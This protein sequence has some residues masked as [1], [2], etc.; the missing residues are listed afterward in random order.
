MIRTGFV[1]RH[2]DV[3]NEANKL[4]VDG[5][6]KHTLSTFLKA[7]LQHILRPCS[8]SLCRKI[9]RKRDQGLFF[10]A[11]GETIRH[12]HRFPCSCVPN[13]D[14]PA[15][16]LDQRMRAWG[17]SGEIAEGCTKMMTSWCGRQR[18]RHHASRF[19]AMTKEYRVV[20]LVGT[21]MSEKFMWDS[22]MKG[23]VVSSQGWKSLDSTSKT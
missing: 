22:Y 5:C 4:F 7:N 11:R 10:D 19:C 13:E 6:T 1:S 8:W 3:I 23:L 9:H 15:H 21:R 14:R 17:I 12:D 2:V 16:H 18:V 20:S